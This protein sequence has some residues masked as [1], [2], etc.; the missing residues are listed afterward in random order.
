MFVKN[1]IQ[2]FFQKVNEYFKKV[3]VVLKCWIYNRYSKLYI[4]NFN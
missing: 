1:S 2:K 3:Y 4:R